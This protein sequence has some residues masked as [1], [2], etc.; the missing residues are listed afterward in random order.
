MEVEEAARSLRMHAIPVPTSLTPAAPAP[1]TPPA[2]F[3][4]PSQ[5]GA[6]AE[7]HEEH[8]GWGGGGGRRRRS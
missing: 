6:Q 8:R 2:A 1:L 7:T 5:V 3:A 4:A